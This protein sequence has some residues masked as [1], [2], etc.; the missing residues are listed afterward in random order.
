M[1]L[2]TCSAASAIGSEPHDLNEE[3][4]YIDRGVLASLIDEAAMASKALLRPSLLS[5]TSAPIPSTV[6][7]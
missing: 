6:P 4:G 3:T 7:T 5:S 2:P 1:Q